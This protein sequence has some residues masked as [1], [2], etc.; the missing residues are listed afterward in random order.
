MRVS[1][2]RFYG[3][4]ELGHKSR[5]AGRD[6][7]ESARDPS[8]EIGAEVRHLDGEIA[9]QFPQ[10]C[11]HQLVESFGSPVQV[12]SRRFGESIDGF[13][14]RVRQGQ[15]HVEGHLRFESLTLR[16]GRCTDQGVWAFSRDPWAQGLQIG[17]TTGQVH[18]HG[19]HLDL[20]ADDVRR[21]RWRFVRACTRCPSHAPRAGAYEHQARSPRKRLTSKH[22]TILPQ[23]AAEALGAPA[24]RSG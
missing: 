14:Q 5:R 9:R 21:S 17:Q 12:L 13:L 11:M 22:L 6:S 1:R 2:S 18:T 8:R 20:T 7:L 24:R 19:R 15:R 16:A 10:I 23:R 3:I 4:V